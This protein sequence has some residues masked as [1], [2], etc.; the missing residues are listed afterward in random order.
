MDMQQLLKQAQDM[1]KKFQEAQDE[2]EEKEFSG[3]AGG[4]MVSAVVDGKGTV[5]EIDIDP[6]VVD[7]D[8]VEMLEDMVLSAIQTGAEKA[9]KEKE[10]LLDGMGPGGGMG[11]LDSLLG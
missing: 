1:Q 5:K 11:G 3:Q 8:E 9:E 2:L 10:E 7:P 4:G 6:E